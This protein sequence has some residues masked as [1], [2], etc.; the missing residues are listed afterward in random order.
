MRLAR[1]TNALALSGCTAA[2]AGARDHHGTDSN[3]TSGST[4]PRQHSR[5]D[6]Q[7]ART[8]LP[9]RYLRKQLL[10]IA[11]GGQPGKRH[12]VHGG[13]FHLQWRCPRS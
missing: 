9:L 4:R 11:V 6:L 5:Q 8:S 7:R 13:A 2:P 10:F 3:V 1:T 12:W